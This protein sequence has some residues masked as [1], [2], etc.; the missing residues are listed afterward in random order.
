M[1]SDD[2]KLKISMAAKQH[3]VD[4][5]VGMVSREQ[6]EHAFRMGD[7]HGY[8]RAIS[9]LRGMEEVADDEQTKEIFRII[10]TAMEKN[11]IMNNNKKDETQ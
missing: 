2:E 3:A 1:I 7:D 5:G 4:W 6:R 9:H 10:Y 8:R 11:G